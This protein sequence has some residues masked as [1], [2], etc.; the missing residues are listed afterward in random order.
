MTTGF[1]LAESEALKNK[2][3][4]L[5]LTDTRNPSGNPVDVFFRYPDA[6]KQPRYPFI[7]I[8]MLGISERKEVQSSDQ[9]INVTY[10]P[11][12]TTDVHTL[13][14]TPPASNYG[15]TSFE[16]I[17]VWL[18]FQVRTFARNHNHDIQLHSK[19]F[20]TNR[21]P[22]RWGYLEIPA[23]GTTRRLDLLGWTQADRYERADDANKRIFSKVY[24]LRTNAEL[25][26]FTYS[27]IR[28]VDTVNVTVLPTD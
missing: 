3:S 12:E 19:L 13:Y 4:G 21:I 23:D 15:V 18:M 10:W 16:F 9:P 14:A 22:F 27:A 8:E 20:S 25:T 28:E 11:D 6:E 2:L 1:L 7:T 24:T 5:Q 17:P 26:P